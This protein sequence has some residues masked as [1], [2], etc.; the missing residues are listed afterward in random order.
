MPPITSSFLELLSSFR[1]AFCGPVY[2]NFVVL[3]IGAVLNK[4]RQTV[5]NILRVYPW[6]LERHWSCFHHFLSTVQWSPLQLSKVLCSLILARIPS[7]QEVVLI[8]DDTLIRRWGKNVFRISVHRDPIRSGK[9]KKTVLAHGHEWLVISILYKTSLRKRPWALPV[10]VF[11]EIPKKLFDKEK[12]QTGKRTGSY[13]SPTEWTI[14]GLRLLRRWFPSR[15]FMILADGNLNTHELH[16]F[17]ANNDQLDATGHFR[18]DSVLH[19]EP[20]EHPTGKRGR[21]RKVGER[22]PSPGVAAVCA[23]APWTKQT[24]QWYGNVEKEQFLLSVEACWYRPGETVPKVRWVVVR[25]PE[26]KNKNVA[27]SSSRITMAPDEIVSL[28]VNRWLTETAFEES[29]KHLKIETAENWAKKSVQ[30]T[31]PLLFGLFSL[32]IL[33]YC[34]QQK[35]GLIFRETWYLKEEPTFSDALTALRIEIWMKTIFRETKYPQGF[36]KKNQEILKLI[37]SKAA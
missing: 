21:P 13:R 7:D 11:P 34:D 9:G 15:R 22:L 27:L 2:R 33:W 16:R 4:G 14:L 1:Y 17:V 31:V 18:M 29:R 35:R 3:A 20:P 26:E 23:D 19:E 10:F 30:R 28:Y 25:D 37:I 32:I 8:A 24:C 6:R 5:C 36:L 12:T